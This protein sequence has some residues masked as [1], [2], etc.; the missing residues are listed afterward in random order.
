MSQTYFLS[1]TNMHGERL[2]FDHVL[3]VERFKQDWLQVL[4]EISG[5]VQVTGQRRSARTS[6]LDG[7][8]HNANHGGA[9]ELYARALRDSPAICTICAIYAKDYSCLGYELPPRC[10]S[11]TPEA[12]LSPPTVCNG[13]AFRCRHADMHA[14]PPFDDTPSA[15]AWACEDAPKEVK[16][17]GFPCAFAASTKDAAVDNIWHQRTAYRNLLASRYPIHWQGESPVGRFH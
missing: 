7:T 17:M 12:S 1:A 15:R 10:R 11:C 4:A 5:D 2:H 16:K 14:L 13:G 9:V 6:D 8:R 3:K